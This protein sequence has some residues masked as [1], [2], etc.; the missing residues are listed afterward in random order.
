MTGVPFEVTRRIGLAYSA[1]LRE[2]R[3]MELEE[4]A[5]GGEPAREEFAREVERQLGRVIREAY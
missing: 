5:V 3:Y 2:L 4:A 1:L